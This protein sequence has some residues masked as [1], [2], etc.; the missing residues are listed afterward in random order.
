MRTPAEAVRPAGRGKKG[1][2]APPLCAA[3]E[4]IQAAVLIRG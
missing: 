4:S 1:F 3:L 2:A